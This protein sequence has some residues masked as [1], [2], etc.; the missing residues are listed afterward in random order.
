MVVLTPPRYCSSVR[1]VPPAV[2]LFGGTL[3]DAGTN[4]FLPYSTAIAANFPF[5]GIDFFD[6]VPHGR[7]S[8]GR[9]VA[10]EVARRIGF[11]MSPPSYLSLVAG[12]YPSYKFNRTIT[13]RGVN[14]ASAFSGILSSTGRAYG[15]VPYPQQVRQFSTSV[16]GNLTAVLGQPGSANFI[17]QSFFLFSVGVG[18][19]VEYIQNL[20]AGRPYYRSDDLF[21][22]AL[23]S[24][25]VG[26]LLDLYAV[27]LRRSAIVAPPP[28][29]CL[30]YFR[31]LNATGG[32]NA[33]AN[34]LSQAIYQR[35]TLALRSLGASAP[36][37]IYAIGNTYR[38]VSDLLAFPEGAGLKELRAPCCGNEATPCSPTATLCRN[39]T[40]YLFWDQYSVTEYAVGLLVEAFF[41]DNTDYVSPINFG[42][43]LIKY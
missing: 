34:S 15:Q 37:L 4:G 23:I 3:V 36:G 42:Q 10:D 5:Y 13:S 25:F 29:G 30:P 17:R 24:Q 19:T 11:E 14:F 9:V 38:F 12:G 39:R 41:S 7:F 40:E 43:L 16:A 26:G 28:I 33:R 1:I 35:L 21:L 32:C 31:A 8:N 20:T 22:D 6:S 27:G 18:D 2:F